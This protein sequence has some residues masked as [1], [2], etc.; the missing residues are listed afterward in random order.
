MQQRSASG[1]R[2]AALRQASRVRAAGSAERV[3]ALQQP[4]GSPERCAV[5]RADGLPARCAVPRAD[6]S[7]G[8]CAVLRADGS[9]GGCAVR[10]PEQCAVY[11][12]GGLQGQ[13][14]LLMPD[15]LPVPVK[16][17]CAVQRAVCPAAPAV[18][19]GYPF[20]FLH[21][22]SFGIPENYPTIISRQIQNC[23]FFCRKSAFAH[24]SCCFQTADSV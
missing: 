10:V 14:A 4:D 18:F 21:I 1:N 5:L 15:V 19:H 3:S 20:C 13:D 16:R 7:P 22:R 11:V 12:P 24:V 17:I 6:G 8:E 2:T 9:P 23:K